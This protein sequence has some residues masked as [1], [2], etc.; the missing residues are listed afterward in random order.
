MKKK[1]T[2]WFMKLLGLGII[3]FGLNYLAVKEYAHD[4]MLVDGVLVM[5]GKMSVSIL[6]MAG[7]VIVI[8]LMLSMLLFEDFK[9]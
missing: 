4:Y 1:V 2:K 6:P 7:C 5:S 3:G 8:I 9:D